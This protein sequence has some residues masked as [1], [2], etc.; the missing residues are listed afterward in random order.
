ME[1]L[2]ESRYNRVAYLGNRTQK[3]TKCDSI[4]ICIRLRGK[5]VHW[6]GDIYETRRER[7][8]ER[9]REKEREREKRKQLDIMM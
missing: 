6:G 3:H 7:E 2:V 1:A 5:I 8:R 4:I 9:K